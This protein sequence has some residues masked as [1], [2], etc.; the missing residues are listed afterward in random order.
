[1]EWPISW[2]DVKNELD[3]V[4][5]VCF[6]LDACGMSPIIGGAMTSGAGQC[7]EVDK[8]TDDNFWNKIPKDSK[9]S[10]KITSRDG[11]VELEP[12]VVT[13]DPGTGNVIGVTAV[14]YAAIGEIGS[15][16]VG[17]GASVM[18]LTRIDAT[19]SKFTIANRILD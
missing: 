19:T 6:D 5:T 2:N 10:M 16:L 11:V 3:S 8:M 12:A 13:R 7:F 15:S 9:F 1:M 18:N 4:K 14:M 17:A